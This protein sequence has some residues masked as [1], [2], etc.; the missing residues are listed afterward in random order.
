LEPEREIEQI[1]NNGA[2]LF[3]VQYEKENS[4]QKAPKYNVNDCCDVCFGLTRIVR[5][6][7]SFHKEL[8]PKAQYPVLVREHPVG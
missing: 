5:A 8:N 6:A 7:I 3:S 4:R 2:H 1:N